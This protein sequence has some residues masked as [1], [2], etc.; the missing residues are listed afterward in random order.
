MCPPP[1]ISGPL[2]EQQNL[3]VPELRPVNNDEQGYGMP[4]SFWNESF[5]EPNYLAQ[6]TLTSSQTSILTPQ[7]P[8]YNQINHPT[9]PI[10][11]TQAVCQSYTDFLFNVLPSPTSTPVYDP[12]QAENTGA[13][14]G[15][16]AS[17]SH[18]GF[19]V[20]YEVV[21]DWRM[22]RDPFSSCWTA[23]DQ[24]V[25]G[26]DN[27]LEQNQINLEGVAPVE[28]WPPEEVLGGFNT[29]EPVIDEGLF[30]TVEAIEENYQEVSVVD[31]VDSPENGNPNLRP[32][33]TNPDPV[34][35]GMSVRQKRI[36]RMR[37]GTRRSS[38]MSLSS[39]ELGRAAKG[40]A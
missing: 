40:A 24:P 23:L 31:A 27:I 19:P 2:P 30:G 12:A 3:Y 4:M 32:S 20:D 22:A 28:C 39:G 37:T 10:S 21:H 9:H 15:D 1:H 29:T 25:L 14:E 11:P 33:P 6:P 8:T 18:F 34:Y 5:G 13:V 17:S 26:I 36:A 38:R 16:Y 35:V 7:E